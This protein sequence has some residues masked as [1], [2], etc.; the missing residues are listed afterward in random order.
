MKEFKDIVWDKV[1]SVYGK[2]FVKVFA[3]PGDKFVVEFP[4]D[5]YFK[6]LHYINSNFIYLDIDTD[7][8]S[9]IKNIGF[10]KIVFNEKYERSYLNFL[11]G[12][13]KSHKKIDLGWDIYTNF[14]RKQENILVIC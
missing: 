4:V 5:Y 7:L 13:I 8:I 12:Y 2:R 3:F 1:R 11:S 6:E 10:L 14:L 9:H